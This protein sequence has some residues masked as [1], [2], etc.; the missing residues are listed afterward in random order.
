MPPAK[1]KNKIYFGKEVNDAIVEYNNKEL[2]NELKLSLKQCPVDLVNE[3]KNQIKLIELEKEALFTSKIWPAINKLVENII[4]KWKFYNYESTYADLKA[5]VVS[6]LFENLHKYNPET[7]SKA[8]SY[9]TIVARNYLIQRSQTLNSQRNSAE[10]LE[11]VDFERD[12]PLEV[13]RSEYQESLSDFIIKWIQYIELNFS[14]FFK[15]S[16]NQ[17]I[18]DSILE[19]F[20][21]SH[22]IDL[23]NKKMIYIL[24]KERSGIESTVHITKILNK[25]KANFY[26]NFE[27]YR[28]SGKFSHKI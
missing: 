3:Y 10:D 24:V 25:L 18:A 20:R 8:Y 1:K 7:G 21:I 2:I 23:S 6:Y 5:D 17:R 26:K 13:S 27:E 11:V 22:E 16:M 19:I 9:F 28:K 14:S 15:T 4:H 12:L